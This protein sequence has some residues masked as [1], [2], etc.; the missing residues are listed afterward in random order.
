MR[1]AAPRMAAIH[2]KLSKS[3][4]PARGAGRLRGV[5]G[6]DELRETHVVGRGNRLWAVRSSEAE[7]RPF[8]SGSPVCP[9]LVRHHIAHLGLQVARDPYR[10][11]RANQTGTFFLACLGGEGRV[12]VDGRWQRLGRGTACLLLPHML[13][14]FHAV[15]GKRWEFCWVRYQA[16]AHRQPRVPASAPRLARF[17]GE[18]LRHAI[19]GLYHECAAGGAGVAVSDAVPHWVE[20]I[21]S[22]VMRFARPWQVDHRLAQVWEEVAAG[23]SEAWS[24]ERLA[25][26][27]HMSGEHLRRLCQRELGRSPKQHVTFLRMRRAAEL[28]AT[29]RL[30]IEVI[31]AE[32]GYGNPFVFSTTFKRATGW[33]PSDYPGRRSRLVREGDLGI[34]GGPGSRGHVPFE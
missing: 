22:Q 1:S 7:R 20:L 10:I 28:L 23:L 9:V 30:K 2:E 26:M 32:V 11:V 29:T 21:Q 19:L 4:P 14:A 16:A 3:H 17:D 6:S 34:S 25:G 8:L 15:P 33:R 12:L 5:G 24:L 31:A 18:P 13:N 27:A